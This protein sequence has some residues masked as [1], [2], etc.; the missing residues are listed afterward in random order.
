MNILTDSLIMILEHPHLKKGY[1]EFKKYLENAG[2]TEDAAALEH[3]LK[4]KFNDTDDSN[5]N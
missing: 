1:K 3:L 5:T 4:T 2:R